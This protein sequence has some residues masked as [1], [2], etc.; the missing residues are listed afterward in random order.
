MAEMSLEEFERGVQ[1]RRATLTPPT[2]LSL[3]EFEAETISPALPIAPEVASAQ[4]IIGRAFAGETGVR[5]TPEAFV[6]AQQGV[7]AQAATLA[8]ALQPSLKLITP[9]PAVPAPAPDRLARLTAPLPAELGAPPEV[10]P[11]PPGLEQFGVSL[12]QLMRDDPVVGSVLRRLEAQRERLIG[13]EQAEAVAAQQGVSNVERRI[14]ANQA[15]T[16]E[17]SLR[18]RVQRDLIPHYFQ[19]GARAYLTYDESV[20]F[21]D[22]RGRT[23]AQVDERVAAAVPPDRLFDWPANVPTPRF[24]RKDVEPYDPKTVAEKGWIRSISDALK[25]GTLRHL[26]GGLAGTAASLLEGKRQVGPFSELASGAYKVLRENPEWQTRT[27]D[28]PWELATSPAALATITAESIPYMAAAGLAAFTGGALAGPKGAIAGAMAVTYAVEGEAAYQEVIRQGGTEHQA[29]LARHIHGLVGGAIE[30]AQFANI[31]RFAKGGRGALVRAATRNI[32]GQMAA[33]KAFTKELLILGIENAVQEGLQGVS[34]EVTI[35]SVTGKPIEPGFVRRRLVDMVGGAGM[36]VIT[37]LGGRGATV[38]AGAKQGVR[39]IVQRVRQEAISKQLFQ[40][41]TTIGQLYADGKFALAKEVQA[42]ADELAE[43]EGLPKISDTFAEELVSSTLEPEV[44]SER[45]A[46]PERKPIEVAPEISG[47]EALEAPVAEGETVPPQIPVPQPPV[48]E[49][50]SPLETRED[51][52]RRAIEAAKRVV[53]PPVEEAAPTARERLAERKVEAEKPPRADLPGR[54]LK[55][56]PTAEAKVKPEPIPTARKPAKPPVALVP[57]V[58]EK[59]VQPPQVQERAA[60]HKRMAEQVR[61]ANA[62]F[63]TG[64][65]VLAEATSDIADAIEGNVALTSELRLLKRLAKATTKAQVERVARQAEKELLLSAIPGTRESLKKEELAITP[66][67]LLRQT[68][69]KVQQASAKAFL[70]GARDVVAS[71]RNLAEYINET[72]KPLNVTASEQAR[73]IKVLAKARTAQEKRAVIASVDMIASRAQTR[74]VLETGRKDVEKKI[75]KGIKQRDFLFAPQMQA[76]ARNLRPLVAVGKMREFVG[77]LR[78]VLTAEFEKNADNAYRQGQLTPSIEALNELSVELADIDEGTNLR[79]LPADL[80]GRITRTLSDIVHAET[81]RNDLMAQAM[82][83]KA[84][85]AIAESREDFREFHKKSDPSEPSSLIAKGRGKVVAFIRY[86]MMNLNTL[87]NS[88]YGRQSVGYRITFEQPMR[89]MSEDIAFQQ[90]SQQ[91]MSD[92]MDGAKGLR[93]ASKKKISVMIGGKL[94][95]LRGAQ[96]A[97]MSALLM[98]PRIRKAMSENAAF[99]FREGPRFRSIPVSEADFATIE[100]ATPEKLRK[101]AQGWFNWRNGIQRDAL[102]DTSQ[103]ILGRDIAPRKDVMPSVVDR[104]EVIT[105]PRGLIREYDRRHVES[106]GRWKARVGGATELIVGDI[107]VAWRRDVRQAGTYAFKLPHIIDMRRLNQSMRKDMQ[108]RMFDGD[109]VFQ[110]VDNY[111]L[112]YQGLQ[113]LKLSQMDKLASWTMRRFYIGALGA[114]AWVGMGQMASWA[115][116]KAQIPL[117]HRKAGLAGGIVQMRK[118]WREMDAIPRLRARFHGHA[119]E[120]SDPANVTTADKAAGDVSF[121]QKLENTVM[122]HIS[123]F[124]RITLGRIYLSVKSMGRSKGLTGEALQEFVA[125]ETLRIVDETQPTFDPLTMTE[126]QAEARKRPFKRLLTAFSNQPVKTINA[127]LNAVYDARR[128]LITK[129]KATEIILRGHVEQVVSLVILRRLTKAGLAVGVTAAMHAL[130]IDDDDEGL[131]LQTKI[132]DAVVANVELDD[133]VWELVEKTAGIVP[134][135]REPSAFALGVARSIAD[136]ELFRL[137]RS[138][139]QTVFAA[140]A[141]PLTKSARRLFR[142]TTSKNEVTRERNRNLFYRDIAETVGLLTKLPVPAARLTLGFAEKGGRLRA[143]RAKAEKGA[144]DVLLEQAISAVR[145]G[146]PSEARRLIKEFNEKKTKKQNF[147]R[148]SDIERRRTS[149]DTAAFTQAREKAAEA[150]IDGKDPKAIIDKYME[151]RLRGQKALTL[152]DAKSEA[153]KIKAKRTGKAVPGTGGASFR[154]P[155]PTRRRTRLR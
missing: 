122:A 84:E 6:Q 24:V 65:K 66:A 10:Q 111:I 94:R 152:S 36:S 77:N 131:D 5:P 117:R 53:A 21:G 112:R 96:V 35:A 113:P 49:V 30:V 116:A 7:A 23:A 124:D 51:A 125:E 59:R 109:D 139:S 22:R 118:S 69:Q 110:S 60:L 47:R 52:E 70:A 97:H 79:N 107:R 134:V 89:G 73:I 133:T 127:S 106:L 3:E 150:I 154:R 19:N 103:S 138:S 92:A 145:D 105:D 93:E 45:V 149:R 151:S 64:Q 74:E 15:E 101:F 20:K 62:A 14:A 90:R 88:L 146:N 11:Q 46:E 143:A 55:K 126:L 26:V 48:A 43:K 68:M 71:N 155:S 80:A 144:A 91:F 129:K 39:A 128:G 32:Q 132:A 100:Q 29:Q 12:E 18:G 38:T 98:D 13:D 99:K 31:L 57:P 27:P 33:G 140:A 9:A 114:K 63:K 4:A 37:G 95:K 41:N 135:L 50:V 34:E 148:L 130:G 40:M 54:E 81:R 16:R 56:P 17:E 108:E 75:N 28:D 78:T 83:E 85:E 87:A 86:A 137:S 119:L 25:T 153:A 123:I 58:M 2:E 67:K 76:M 61:I 104:S 147:V 120:L 102:N 1:A 42:R 115:L 136:K 44:P 142:W 72:L 8:Q 121:G 82:K 141:A